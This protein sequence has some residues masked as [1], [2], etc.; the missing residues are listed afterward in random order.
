MNNSISSISSEKIKK[1][2]QK[3]DKPNFKPYPKIQ[4]YKP[5]QF[6]TTKDFEELLAFLETEPKRKELASTS[7]PLTQESSFVIFGEE[8]TNFLFRFFYH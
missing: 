4:N 5:H 8:E 1:I 7:H 3:Q 2:I 6:A